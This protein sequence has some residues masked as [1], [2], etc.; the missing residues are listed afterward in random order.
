VA[1]LALAPLALH[2]CA[3]GA[4]APAPSDDEALPDWSA[5]MTTVIDPLYED[6]LKVQARGRPE[7][8]DLAGIARAADRSARA[9]ALGHGRLRRVQPK[10]FTA[11]ARAAEA[12]YREV[13]AAARAGQRERVREL[14]LAGERLHCD[15]CHDLANR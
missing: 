2:A 1:I 10:E 14:V 6:V 7:A 12:W 4:P 11:L 15:R 8:M 3:G 13:E 9:M 5:V